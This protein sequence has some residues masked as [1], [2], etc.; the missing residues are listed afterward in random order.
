MLKRKTRNCCRGIFTLIEL[1]VVIAIIAILASML[2]PALNKARDKA[3]A[4]KCSSNLKQLGTVS[5]LYNNDFDDYILFYRPNQNQDKNF[6]HKSLVDMGYLNYNKNSKHTVI[7]CPANNFPLLSEEY[8]VSYGK[9]GWSCFD[10]NNRAKN[11]GYSFRTG[12]ITA[13]SKPSEMMHF[14]DSYDKDANTAQL[15]TLAWSSSSQYIDAGM[16]GYK[17]NVVYLDGHCGTEK[18]TRWPFWGIDKLPLFWL[19]GRKK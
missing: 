3:K 13:L 14:I 18:W 8:Y 6:W 5:S 12:R 10:L 17:N 11:S 7:T 19:G 16:H 15:I 9:N 4:I 1:L 2:L